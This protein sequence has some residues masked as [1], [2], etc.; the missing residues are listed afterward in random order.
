MKRLRGD[1]AGGT[2]DQ[3]S[4]VLF[5]DGL[6]ALAVLS[7][8][9]FH[10]A[11]TDTS[12]PRWSL[13][14]SRGV[15]LFFVISGF[16]LAFPFLRRWRAGA[17]W[18]LDARTLGSFL[19]RRFSRIAPAYYAVLAVLAFL[20]ATPFGYPAIDGRFISAATA[21]KEIV[22]DVLFLTSDAPV[23]NPSFWSLGLEMRWYV[24]CPL[25]IALFMRSRVLFAGVALLMYVLYFSAGGIEDEGTLP[26]FMAGI[27]AADIVICERRWTRFAWIGAAIFILAGF[28]QQNH[29]DVSEHG[30]PVWHAAAFF[31]VLSASTGT[32]RRLFEWRPL[33]LIG[34]ASYSIYLVH[35]PFLD[36]L[37]DA[38]VPAGVAALATL[39]IGFLAYYLFERPLSSPKV[40]SAI[41]RGLTAPRVLF[42]QLRPLKVKR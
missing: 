6:R 4:H 9:G 30:N 16:C 14:G 8:L 31:L 40:R 24:F 13:C 28:I 11:Q 42:P 38:G 17:A 21:W 10:I 22:C 27:V 19:V 18:R 15:D 12:A 23:H 37:V 29:S 35:K 34:V 2:A 33:C 7:V 1:L 39:A 36:S 41:E 20:A 5:I 32:A 3:K 25:L 26:C